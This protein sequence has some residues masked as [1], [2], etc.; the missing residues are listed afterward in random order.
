MKTIDDVLN[1]FVVPFISYTVHNLGE[2]KLLE[3]VNEFGVFLFIFDGERWN[4]IPGNSFAKEVKN[5]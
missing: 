4:I 1:T 3:V 5:V 2:Y